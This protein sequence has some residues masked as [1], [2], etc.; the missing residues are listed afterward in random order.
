WWARWGARGRG[1]WTGFRGG[2]GG[3]PGGSWPLGGGMVTP[4]FDAVVADCFSPVATLTTSTVRPAMPPVF[5]EPRTMPAMVPRAAGGFGPR[6]TTGTP[7]RQAPAYSRAASPTSSH[8]VR[9]RLTPP[10]GAS[11][12]PGKS[13]SNGSVFDT[14]GRRPH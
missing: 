7:R 1:A 13:F 4:P 6:S 2:G 5:S 14:D 9:Q 11:G 3:G 8:P 10:F 12:T